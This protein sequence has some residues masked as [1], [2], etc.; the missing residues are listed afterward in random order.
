MSDKEP[1]GGH[2]DLEVLRQFSPTSYLPVQTWKYQSTV[3]GEPTHG[4]GGQ[5]CQTVIPQ[6]L[7]E[8]Y[9]PRTRQE[10]EAVKGEPR[11]LG[12]DGLS[13]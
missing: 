8:P 13:G 12:P 5:G 3:Q 10:P 6:A 11:S 1:G 9:T 2:S 7:P 4:A